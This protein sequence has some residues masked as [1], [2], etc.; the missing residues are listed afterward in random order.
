MPQANSTISMPRCD[1]ARGVALGLAVLARDERGDLVGVPLEQLLEA[2]HARAL[3][4]RR[5]A[6][7]DSG[8]LGGG[9]G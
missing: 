2:E 6:P 9:D 4:R 1:F 7:T 3:E 5:R 8:L